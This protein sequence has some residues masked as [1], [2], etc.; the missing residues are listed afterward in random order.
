M[1]GLGYRLT[2]TFPFLLGTA[3][4]RQAM[5]N[6]T[7]P[8]STQQAA[9]STQLTWNQ[10]GCAYGP[11]LEPLCPLISLPVTPTRSRGAR[12]LRTSRRR[13]AGVTSVR[14][15]QTR[16]SSSIRTFAG[17]IST[18]TRGLVRRLV[19]VLQALVLSTW[20]RIRGPLGRSIG[21][22]ILSISTRLDEM[23]EDGSVGAKRSGWIMF[24]GFKT[25]YCNMD[26]KPT[27][28]GGGFCSFYSRWNLFMY[29]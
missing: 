20:R 16:R 27:C 13:M 4:A 19:V 12:R 22:S 7:A 15:S 24:C 6:P 10:I 18:R 26:S 2:N 14:T 1:L 11:G 9:A 23:G 17:A 3:A 8:V 28:R 29:N 5:I 21:F 25:A